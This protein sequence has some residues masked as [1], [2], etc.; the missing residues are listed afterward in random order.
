MPVTVSQTLANTQ[1][2]TDPLGRT[3]TLRGEAVGLGR[4]GITG[5][6]FRWA[7]NFDG[8]DDRGQ[9]TYRAIDPDG[10]IEI[11]W[12]SGDTVNFSTSRTIISQTNTTNASSQEFF[13]FASTGAGIVVR[14]GGTAGGITG[15][16]YSANTKYK[17]SMQGNNLRFWVNDKLITTQN[18]IRG[19]VREPIATTIIG[20]AV[21]SFYY[22]GSLYNVK[23]NGTLWPMNERD[24]NIQLPAPSGL[25]A[26]LITQSVLENPAVKGSQ[27]T[28]LGDGR[29]QYVGDGTSN[30][31]RFLT[32]AA[33][34]AQGFIEF[35]VES[36]TGVGQMRVTSMMQGA[37]DMVWSG[38]GG[39]R[40][41][42]TTGVDRVSFD[43]NSGLVSC[44]IKNISFKPLGTCNPLTLA[45]TTA[46]RWEE[47][48]Q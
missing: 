27:W 9:L 23:I 41:F 15:V 26:E 47:I 30:E 31:L 45:N 19:A 12:Q 34:P 4:V 40:W 3:A 18:F 43:R 25:G 1:Q 28:Y 20:S 16:T 37:G 29:W 5:R 33:T 32:I 6:P 13:I 8:L 14:V 7:Y 11:E 48:G 2:L 36:Y 17:L 35:E 10:D 44:I 21:N 24:Q 46:D 39:K 22:L 38:A 42:Y